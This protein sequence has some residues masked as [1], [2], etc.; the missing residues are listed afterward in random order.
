MG[1]RISAALSGP[2]GLVV[3][4]LAVLGLSQAARSWNEA[5]QAQQLRERA[6]PG[7]ILML[8]SSS[9][10]YCQRAQHWLDAERVPYR[11]CLIEQ[12][13]ACAR[14]YVALQA[15]GTPTFLVRGVRVVGWDRATL[16]KALE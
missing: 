9:C 16:L 12:D 1:E 13:A 6:R 5:G 8:A 14:D 10:V 11:M 4:V 7:D 15:P 2:I 3:L